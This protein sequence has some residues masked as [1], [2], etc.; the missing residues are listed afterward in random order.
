MLKAHCVRNQGSVP[1]AQ[2]KADP[3]AQLFEVISFTTALQSDIGWAL[4]D[5]WEDSKLTGRSLFIIGLIYSG[6]DRPRQ[7][8]DYFDVLPSTMTFEL[9]KLLA[10]KLLTRER[11]AG[12]GRSLQLKLTK[13]G[14]ALHRKMM[15]TIDA[16]MKERVSVLAPGELEN[17]LLIGRKIAR[18]DEPHVPPHRAAAA[19]ARTR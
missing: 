17:F 14:E 10:E 9:N 16:F 2:A 5:L 18:L 11:V 4:R 12:D 1:S 3:Y 8:A 7:L 15:A 6:V 19:K 13:A